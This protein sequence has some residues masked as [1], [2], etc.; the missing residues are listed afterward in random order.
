[1]AFRFAS[2]YL[3]RMSLRPRSRPPSSKPSI[4]RVSRIQGN[5]AV[6]LTTIKATDA[7]TAVRRV[8]EDRDITD[9]FEQRRLIARPQD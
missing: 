4:W 6:P 8:I 9:P 2:H 3:S 5:R 7:E 1:M